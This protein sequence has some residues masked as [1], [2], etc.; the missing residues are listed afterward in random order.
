MNKL[1]KLSTV[2]VV[3]TML[4]VTTID[5]AMSF[6]GH[7]ITVEASKKSKPKEKRKMVNNAI[8]L[9]LQQ[10]QGLAQGSLDE[11]LEPTDNGT[12]DPDFAWAMLVTKIKYTSTD[13]LA[14]YVTPDFMNLSKSDKTQVARYAQSTA[15]S[16]L[17]YHY[18][19]WEDSYDRP[20]MRIYETSGDDPFPIGRS[21]ALETGKFTF[22][23]E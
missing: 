11:N 7:A 14:M 9:E 6:C 5:T 23:T 19:E 3:V 2:T 22:E 16:V 20:Y 17:G 4:S 8:A 21:K 1:V 12:T 15:F 10:D 18:K 13:D